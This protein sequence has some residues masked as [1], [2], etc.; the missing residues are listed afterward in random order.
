MPTTLDWS[1]PLPRTHTGILQG[2]GR[3]GVMIWGEG[4]VLRVTVGRADFWDR[5]GREAVDGGDELRRHL[6]GC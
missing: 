2:N 3:M 5:R 1:F 4:N 6:G